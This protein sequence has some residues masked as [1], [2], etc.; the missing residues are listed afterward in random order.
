MDLRTL[1]V[2]RANS[3]GGP[4]TPVGAAERNVTR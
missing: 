1:T 2:R 3:R 4:R